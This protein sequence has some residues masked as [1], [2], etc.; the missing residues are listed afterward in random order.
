MKK[1][2]ID[3]LFRRLDQFENTLDNNIDNMN[4]SVK[5]FV[6]QYCSKPENSILN[7]KD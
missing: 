1:S 2:T 4:A 3:W 7:L 5:E 6:K